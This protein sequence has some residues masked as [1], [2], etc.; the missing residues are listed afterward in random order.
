MKV[1]I[2]SLCDFASADAGGKL[3]II[4]VYNTLWARE[5]PATHGLCALVARLRF[6]K[7]EE[8]LK[9]IKISF[10]DADGNPIMPVMETQVPVQANPWESSAIAQVVSVMS[11][12]RLPSFGEYSIDLAVDGRQESS[13]PLFLRQAPTI[14]PHLQR[15]LPFEPGGA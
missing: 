6:E 15:P 13:T 3:N 14:P 12:L 11:Q 7:I 1:E 9:K 5:A 4:G 10:V 8:G 2:L